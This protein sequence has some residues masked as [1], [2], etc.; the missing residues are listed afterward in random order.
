MTKTPKS[1]YYPLYF[2][3]QLTLSLTLNC[4]TQ[5]EASPLIDKPSQIIWL[6]E[7]AKYFYESTPLGNGRL[8]ALIFGQVDDEK[9]VINESGMWSG[10]PQDSDRNDAAQYLPK[11]KELLIEGKNAEAT[12]LVNAHFT[13]QGK[14]SRSEQYGTY[15]LL[16]LLHL[17]TQSRAAGSPVLNYRRELDLSTAVSS[18]T[19]IQNGIHFCRTA[20]VSAADQ[21]LVVKITADR[22]HSISID[23]K[24]DRQENYTTTGLDESSLMISGQLPDGK[25]G[26]DGVSY[27]ACV[28]AFASGGTVSCTSNILHINDA[29]SVTILV[30]AATDIKTFAGRHTQNVK[31]ATMADMLEAEKKNYDTLIG[32]HILD[33]QKYYNRVHLELGKTTKEIS[34]QA[35]PDRLISLAKGIQD[36]SLETLYFNF[37]RYLLISSSRPGGLPA[38]LQGIWAD[39]LVCPWHADWHLNVNVQMNYW[40][41]EICN[42]SDLHEP[43]FSLIKSL[44]IPGTKTARLYY[45]SKGWVAH[46]ITNP[47]GFTS[48]GESASWGSSTSASA[49]LCE[50]LWDHYLYTQDKDFLKEVYPQLKGSAQ[51]YADMLI[52]EPIHNWLVSAPSNSPENSYILPSGER[53]SVCMGPTI[54]QQIIRYLFSAC[55]EA[56]ELLNQDSKFRT[57]LLDKRSRLAPTQI[58]SDGRIMEWLKEYKEAEVH[59]RH[60]SHLWGLYPGN[61]ITTENTPELAKAARKSLEVRG[62]AGTGWSLAFKLNLWARLHDG[63]HA[64]KILMRQLHLVGVSGMNYKDG[65]GTYPNLFDAHPPFQID[66]NF[67]ASAGIA[68]MLVQSTQ[69]LIELLPALP[70]TWSEGSVSGLKARG[71]ITVDITWYAGRVV[72]YSI[73]SPTPFYVNVKFNGEIH[74]ILTTQI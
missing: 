23:A 22:P 8:G 40:P 9:I 55:I 60:V 27:A 48:P 47:W 34:M 11:I 2:L 29:N 45:N 49:W 42:L 74:H 58:A 72:S 36:Q 33:Y 24:L 10:S 35:T 37:G 46:T 4:K 13:C 6:K 21:V 16:G 12:K 7:P 73:K 68:E 43:L 30:T 44:Q 32:A 14:G 63:D 38:N 51:F 17:Q 26:K 69:Q 31:E 5:L 59:H 3:L 39:T 54:D 19:Y 18:I 15:Q 41:A 57:I 61:E 64:E 71:N 28:K 50:H 62:D 65:G 66:G 67:G 53:L 20:F 52:E 56:S 70:S 1:L 25:S